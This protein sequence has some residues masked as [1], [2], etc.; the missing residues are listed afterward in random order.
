M[1][2][3]CASVCTFCEKT[4]RL[5]AYLSRGTER[6]KSF[7]GSIWNFWKKRCY[8]QRKYYS[9]CVNTKCSSWIV[10]PNNLK[11][12]WN[13]YKSSS[14]LAILIGPISEDAHCWQLVGKSLEFS[15]LS[16]HADYF[17]LSQFSIFS[18]SSMQKA[19]FSAGVSAFSSVQLDISMPPS[20]S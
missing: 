9:I 7:L 8:G 19:K 4:G 18:L 20:I 5:L 11:F 12:I 10:I 1:G 14:F 3:F 17:S 15:D 6:I 16:T 13:I 2:S